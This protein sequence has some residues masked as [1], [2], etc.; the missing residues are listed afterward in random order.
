[1]L[2]SHVVHIR[3]AIHAVVAVEDIGIIR[4]GQATEI[5]GAVVEIEKRL[6]RGICRGDGPAEDIVNK[7][8]RAVAIG[9]GCRATS[10]VSW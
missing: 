10:Q 2:D 5:T 1:M 6:A 7:P 9:N 4:I 3:Q 8:E